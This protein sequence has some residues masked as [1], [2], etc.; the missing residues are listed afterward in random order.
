MSAFVYRSLAVGAAHSAVDVL[1]FKGK[2]DMAEAKRFGAAAASDYVACQAVLAWY[3]D[4]YNIWQPVAS[5]ALYV[6]GNKLVSYDVM[7]MMYQFLIQAGSSYLAPLAYDR[8]AG[9]LAVSYA[10]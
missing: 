9:G 7:S 8:L 5:G 3:P 4:G 1:G 10:K 6:A 2:L